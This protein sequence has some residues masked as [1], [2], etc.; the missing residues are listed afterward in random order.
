MIKVWY[1]A[2]SG[3]PDLFSTLVWTAYWVRMQNV[4]QEME[5]AALASAVCLAS[6][7]ISCATFRVPNR[8]L[9]F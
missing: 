6:Y 9:F 3:I 4:A 1:T 7:S 2:G 8:Y 5:Q